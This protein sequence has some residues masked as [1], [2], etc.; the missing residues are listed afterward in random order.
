MDEDDLVS[1][2]QYNTAAQ[3]T[4]KKRPAPSPSP[5]LQRTTLPHPFNGESEM[6]DD[7]LA[8]PQRQTSVGDTTYTVVSQ[9]SI[10]G[11]KHSEDL[12]ADM[13]EDEDE[14]N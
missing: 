13:T 9:Q 3:R 6:N 5:T 4:A 7:L 1:Y 8:I 2:R 12:L 14:E 11:L 10:V